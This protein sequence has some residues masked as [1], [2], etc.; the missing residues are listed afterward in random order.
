MISR[1]IEEW[2]LTGEESCILRDRW[3]SDI[4]STKNLFTF[5]GAIDLIRS[6]LS[7]NKLSWEGE[8]IQV[9]IL[10]EK[11]YLQKFYKNSG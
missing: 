1:V 6:Q 5:S 2:L 11:N 10:I 8:V 9:L 7:S 3:I 4:S